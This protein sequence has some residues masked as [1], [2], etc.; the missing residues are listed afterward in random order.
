MAEGGGGVALDEE[1]AVPGQAVAQQGPQQEQPEPPPQHRPRHAHHP[2]Q[3]PREVPPPRRRLR[4]LA[5]VER[6]ELLQVPEIHAFSSSSSSSSSF[7][8]F[9]SLSDPNRFLSSLPNS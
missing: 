8:F 4:V 7:S 3:R 1:V 2:A 9:P 5:H 6:P